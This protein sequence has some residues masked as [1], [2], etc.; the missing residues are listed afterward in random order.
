MSSELAFTAVALGYFDGVHLGHRR[1]LSAAAVWA[2]EHGCISTAFTFY[3]DARRTKAPDIL[4]SEERRRRL[5]ACGMRQVVCLPFDEIAALS[6]RQFVCE[7]LRDRL[8]A[9]AVFCGENFRFGRDA[10]GDVTLLRQLCAEVGMATQ[11]LPLT[12]ADGRPVSSTRIRALLTA[13]DVAAAAALLG[14]PY[15]VEL[16]VQHGAA[17]GRTLGWPTVNQVFP[18]GLLRPADGVYRTAACVDGQW[19][20]AATGIGTR[21]TVTQGSFAADET[22]CRD[23]SVPPAVSETK[24]APPVTCE[25]FLCRWQGDAYGKSIRLAFLDYLWPVRRYDTLEQLSACIRR[26]VRISCDAFDAGFT[27]R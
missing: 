13:G 1:I 24:S 15:T 17:L 10:A 18:A 27:V 25:S 19:M 12:M 9:A 26:A 22:A 21:P 2:A 20:P 14:E 11:V 6:P 5:T 8:H 4:S 3:F 7:I 23:T 16:P